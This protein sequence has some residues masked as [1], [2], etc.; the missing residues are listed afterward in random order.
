MLLASQKFSRHSSMRMWFVSPRDPIETSNRVVVRNDTRLVFA[1]VICQDGISVLAIS[2]SWRD[3]LNAGTFQSVQLVAE[4][5]SVMVRALAQAISGLRGHAPFLPWCSALRQGKPSVDPPDCMVL[6]ETTQIVQTWDRGALL[7]DVC[8]SK[9]APFLLVSRGSIH[10]DGTVQQGACPFA[11]LADMTLLGDLGAALEKLS[12][13]ASP[14][15]C[16][17]DS[18][19]RDA[20]SVCVAA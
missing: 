6:S 11:V 3:E 5:D 10:P 16:T 14:S 15:D 18:S 2:D 13:L 4:L 9:R 1:E 8:I 19:S 12:F 17:L 7:V 20:L